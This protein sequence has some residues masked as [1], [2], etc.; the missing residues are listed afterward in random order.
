MTHGPDAIPSK[1]A[2]IYCGDRA[3][4]LTDEHVVPLGMGGKHVLLKASCLCC[5]KVTSRFEQDVLRDLWGEA[6]ISYGSPTRHRLKRAS[7]THINMMLPD[8]PRSID[9]PVSEYPAAM[10]YYEMG[11]AGALAGL[12]PSVD[13]S[14][15]WKLTTV[16][17]QQKLDA[18]PSKYG[19]SPTM[20]FRHVPVSFG[21]TMVKIGYCQILTALDPGDFRPYCLSFLMGQ[22]NNLSHVV[23]SNGAMDEPATQF[24][25][26]LRTH[27]LESQTISSWWP[28]CVSSQTTRRPRITSWS[29]M[30]SEGTMLRVSGRSWAT[31]QRMF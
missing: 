26:V 24:G 4:M 8:Q 19:V 2:C 18:F 3:V 14:G 29:A 23:G 10:V 21:R 17:D 30:W 25:Y 16:T 27:A 12:H 20:K 5:N 7:K 31:R 1:G 6:R 15:S 9:I 22:R 28:R 11:Q 13:T